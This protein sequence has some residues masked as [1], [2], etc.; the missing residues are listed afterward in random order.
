[1]GWADPLGIHTFE[2]WSGF[3]VSASTP[4]WQYFDLVRQLYESWYERH[5]ALGGSNDLPYIR[6]CYVVDG[7]DLIGRNADL[8]WL[9]GAADHAEL[10]T[11]SWWLTMFPSLTDYTSVLPAPGDGCQV[12]WTGPAPPGDFNHVPDYSTLFDTFMVGDDGFVDWKANI[13]KGLRTLVEDIF[14]N[15]IS[16][17]IYPAVGGS[18]YDG[19]TGSTWDWTGDS[20]T[21]HREIPNFNFFKL[22]TNAGIRIAPGTAAGSTDKGAYMTTSYYRQVKH[23]FGNQGSYI[24]ASGSPA[25]YSNPPSFLYTDGSGFTAGDKA[26]WS[27][28]NQQ[29]QD[30]EGFI[31]Y[32]DLGGDWVVVA[33]RGGSGRVYQRTTGSDVIWGMSEWG[34]TGTNPADL[35]ATL[36]TDGNSVLNSATYSFASGDVSKPIM[37]GG[38]VFYIKSVSAGAATLNGSCGTFTSGSGHLAAW[39]LQ[40]QGVRPDVVNGYGFPQRDHIITHTVFNEIYAMINKCRWTQGSYLWV[41]PEGGNNYGAYETEDDD[42]SWEL[43]ITNR[44]EGNPWA[45]S[46]NDLGP[47]FEQDAHDDAGSYFGGA[48]TETD[49]AQIGTPTGITPIDTR[50]PPHPI[51]CDVDFLVMAGAGPNPGDPDPGVTIVIDDVANSNTRTE[52]DFDDGGSGVVLRTWKKWSSSGPSSVSPKMSSSWLGGAPPPS[53][54]GWL[55]DPKRAPDGVHEMFNDITKG[56][57]VMMTAAIVRWDVAGGMA[58][59]D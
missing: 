23:L 40:P 12:V 29:D 42:E 51:A 50:F 14:N 28:D 47:F 30:A 44:G 7:G 39:I 57:H 17:V 36:D 8:P 38:S 10:Y 24:D 27:G 3:P 25:T 48:S 11:S 1:M 32:T 46:P 55:G 4:S 37:I 16:F 52:L 2:G 59:V 56:W 15:C 18:D 58:Y 41:N 53:E 43:F 31:G 20:V 54:P 19:Y 5:M 35:V 21:F 9:Y 49:M 13:W 33:T 22:A 34:A 6:T 45:V 26:I